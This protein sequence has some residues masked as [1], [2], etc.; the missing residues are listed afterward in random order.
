MQLQTGSKRIVA[1]AEGFDGKHWPRG[2]RQPWS[3]VGFGK[4]PGL[5]ADGT[6]KQPKMYNEESEGKEEP[7]D[8]PYRSARSLYE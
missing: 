8:N 2:D 1:N 5:K 4:G 7:M 6:P 3:D